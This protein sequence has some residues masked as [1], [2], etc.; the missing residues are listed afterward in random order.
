MA[1]ATEKDIVSIIGEKSQFVLL[2]HYNPDGDALGS[3]LA[4]GHVL[5][6]MGKDVFCFHEEPVPAIYRFLPGAGKVSSEISASTNF[7]ADAGEGLCFIALDCG[8]AARLG[9]FS[10]ELLSHHPFVVIDH[11]QSNEGFGDLDWISSHH[12]STGEMVFDLAETL[13][14][15]LSKKAAECLFVAISTD[16]GSF[17]YACTGRSTFLA[18]AKLVSCGVDIAGISN[19]LYN[20]YTLGRVR[21]FQ[22]VLSTLEMYEKDR[23]AV[24]RVTQKMLE[25]TFT[26]LEDIEHFINYPRSI[27]TVQ[28]AVFLKEVEPGVISVSLR[29]KGCCDVAA[30][31]AQFGGGGHKNASGLRLSGISMDA[32]R[33]RLLPLL[34]AKFES[35]LA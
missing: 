14:V 2:T 17:Q 33:D 3:M 15:A 20:N 31:A 12:S 21:L 11:H 35:Q 1:R 8:D 4:L 18:A 27:F 13:P 16:T 24:I 6:E 22:E 34:A 32:L 28:A 5:T 23:I 7:T 29:A 30:V 9:K 19:K 10:A 25:R 26:T